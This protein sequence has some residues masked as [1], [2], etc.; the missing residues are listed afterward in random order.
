MRILKESKERQR[1]NNAYMNFI[2]LEHDF[3][4]E[5]N[6]PNSKEAIIQSI[7]DNDF[8]TSTVEFHAS[9]QH[10]LNRAHSAVLSAYSLDDLNKMKC[11]KVKGISAGFALKPVKGVSGYDIVS[12]HNDSGIKALGSLLM[13]SAIALGGRYLDCFEGYLPDFYAKK[14]FVQYDFSP[15]DPQYDPEGKLKAELKGEKGV[16]FM[17]YKSAPTPK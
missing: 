13:D 11:F 4:I 14:G 9:L 5:E 8:E 2:L 15:Y 7:K 16:V 17:K 1:Y 3:H 10:A 12:V 6:V